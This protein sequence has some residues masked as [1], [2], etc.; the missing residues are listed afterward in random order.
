MSVVKVADDHQLFNAIESKMK[1]LKSQYQ[2]FIVV[3]ENKQILDTFRATSAF[4]DAS[5]HKN[6]IIFDDFSQNFASLMHK[7]NEVAED[8]FLI[9]TTK[10]GA[11][12]VDYKGINP[13]HVIIAFAPESYSECVQA[14]GRG[15]RELSSF[16]EGTI[17]CQDPLTFNASKYLSVL[18]AADGEISEAMKI[19]CKLARTFHGCDTKTEPL[20]ED[21]QQAV[22]TFDLSMLANH[23]QPQLP[24][25]M[26]EQLV[27]KG[28]NIKRI[29]NGGLLWD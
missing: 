21:A 17:I 2:N 19:N 28:K 20:E 5:S 1:E 10:E 3:F 7:L 8:N 11:R 26:L 27:K 22:E 12:G 23:S 24:L 18:Q 16:S 6:N 13:A 9:M 4:I 29:Q 25:L 14:L 15:C